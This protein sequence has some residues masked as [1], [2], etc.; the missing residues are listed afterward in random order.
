MHAHLQSGGEDFA[1]PCH[2]RRQG[3][4]GRFDQNVLPFALALQSEGYPKSAS[5]PI[6]TFIRLMAALARVARGVA[7][8]AAHL[9]FARGLTSAAAGMMP[10]VIS[11]KTHRGVHHKAACGDLVIDVVIK[12]AGHMM[13]VDQPEAGVAAV[14]AFLEAGP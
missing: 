13:F 11:S 5:F 2:R 12:Y 7:V 3:F 10:F 14:R 4:K 9:L 1:P 6:V 8:S